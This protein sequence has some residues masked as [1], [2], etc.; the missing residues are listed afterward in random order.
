[1]ETQ[2]KQLVWALVVV[3]VGLLL[4]V[5]SVEAKIFGYEIKNSKNKNLI[6]FSKTFTLMSNQ[7]MKS[8]SKVER[9]DEAQ[10]K[11]VNESNGWKPK[12]TQKPRGTWTLQV[13]INGAAPVPKD[14]SLR[15]TV[16]VTTDTPGIYRGTDRKYPKAA[17]KK[18][19]AVK[20]HCGF[21]A[22]F[23]DLV[24]SGAEHRASVDSIV[25]PAGGA[26]VDRFGVNIPADH[27]GY[28][29]QLNSESGNDLSSFEIQF[30]GSVTSSGTLAVGHN[31]DVEYD[32]M[33]PADWFTETLDPND[34]IW[35]TNT[36]QP[37]ALMEELGV[38]PG[39]SVIWVAGDGGALG[40][41]TLLPGECSN[42]VYL[43]SPDPPVRDGLQAQVMD[44]E[45]NVSMGMAWGPFIGAVDP[46]PEELAEGVD[47]GIGVVSWS[48]TGVA[49]PTFEVYFG[50]SYECVEDSSCYLGSTGGTSMAIPVLEMGTEYFL[51]VDTVDVAGGN[52]VYVGQIWSF[53]TLSPEC[54]PPLA[55]DANEDC[56]VGMD[57]F[58]IMATEWLECTSQA[59]ACGP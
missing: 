8:T 9:W 30:S 35:E 53:V 32:Y 17:D 19:K 14:T 40:I 56:M 12:A 37:V 15:Y 26:A 48:S 36:P 38:V 11:W 42:M 58:Y 49:G 28:F 27:Y 22:S 29:Y 13:D 31:G 4:W 46:D 5:G 3:M 54:D 59:G 51:R 10:K 25:F 2:R 16:E 41:V 34:P 20:G 39:Q 24:N 47:P 50:D 44:V 23:D 33:I 6:G 43:V 18:D 45:G 52:K 21:P 7:K 55:A 1:M 57:D